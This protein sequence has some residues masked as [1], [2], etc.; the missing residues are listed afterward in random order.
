MMEITLSNREIAAPGLYL[1][2]WQKRTGLVR[3]VGEP[4]RGFKLIAPA[5]ALEVYMDG[6][7]KDGAI[8]TDALFSEP[9]AVKVE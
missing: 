1:M 5:N 3:V 7:P 8:P 9:L 6:L 4:K 2:R